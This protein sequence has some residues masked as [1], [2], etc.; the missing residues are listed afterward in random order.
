[1]KVY[2][3]FHRREQSDAVS[4]FL[5]GLPDFKRGRIVTTS[6]DPDSWKR[7]P[8]AI[9]QRIEQERLARAGRAA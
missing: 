6:S 3:H 4:T 8:A 7:K 5:A 1:M 2:P 9:R